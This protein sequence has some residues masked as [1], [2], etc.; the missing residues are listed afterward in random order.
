LPDPREELPEI[1]RRDLNS[2]FRVRPK[3]PK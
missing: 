3:S 1:L 2:P